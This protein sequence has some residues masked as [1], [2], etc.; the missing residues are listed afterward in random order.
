M[1][2]KKFIFQKKILAS[3]L[4]VVVLFSY[5]PLNVVYGC[6]EEV[7][8]ILSE[9]SEKSNEFIVEEVLASTEGF[10]QE[11]D[12]TNV[13]NTNEGNI[14]DL[15]EIKTEN[16]IINES[17][18]ITN[19][20]IDTNDENSKEENNVIDEISNIISNNVT[21]ST[22]DENVILG[23][24]IDNTITNNVVNNEVDNSNTI[25][26][27]INN[28]IIKEDV[29]DTE[30]V[31]NEKLEIIGKVIWEEIEVASRPENVNISIY[32]ENESNFIEEIII[33]ENENWEFKFS[34]LEKY[35]KNG[36]LINYII[37]QNTLENYETTISVD[38][39]GNYNILNK[40]IENSELTWKEILE[41]GP[42]I[43]LLVKYSEDVNEEISEQEMMI[44]EK[45]KEL[46]FVKG[47]NLA[48][49]AYIFGTDDFSEEE[50]AIYN[51]YQQVMLNGGELVSIDTLDI[52][53]GE[54]AGKQVL[55]VNRKDGQYL[56][57]F[58][59]KREGKN[60]LTMVNSIK[61]VTSDGAKPKEGDT[62]AYC[63][64]VYKPY[65]ED[66]DYN[67]DAWN[68]MMKKDEFKDYEP[69]FSKL[70]SELAYVVSIGCK[71][72]GSH[73]NSEYSTGA[74]SNWEEDYYVTQTVIY[75][76]LDDYINNFDD[77]AKKMNINIKDEDI[78]E[79][80]KTLLKD[81]YS[82]HAFDA[83]K[84]N[85]ED[86]SEGYGNDR[87]QV[88]Y[89]AV[90]KMYNA[91]LKQRNVIGNVDTEGYDATLTVTPET[92]K[93]KYENGNWI[94][95][96]SVNT[97]GTLKG[98]ISFSGP[99]GMET[100]FNTTTN[101]YTIK[102]PATSVKDLTKIKV[103]TIANFDANKF[104]TYM[105]NISDNQNVA[106]YQ[107]DSNYTISKEVEFTLEKTATVNIEGTKTWKDNGNEYNTRPDSITINLL[108]NGVKVDRK[109]VTAQDGWSW[110]FTGHARYD[111][112]NKEIKYTIT[113]EKV[114]GYETEIKNFNVINTLKDTT[115]IIGTKIWIDNNNEYNTRPDS[116]TINLLK[117]GKP[118]NSMV[119]KPD[120][121]GNW[122]YKFENLSKYDENGKL[123]VYTIEE[124][125]VEKY[126][127]VKENE[128]VIVNLLSDKFEISGI[129]I[130]KDNNN[131]YNTRPDSIIINLFKN[132]EFDQKI[133]VK[134]DLLGNWNFKFENLEMYDNNGVKYDY[135]ITE[136][137]VEKYETIIENDKE[138]EFK[139]NI[140][141]KLT[142]TTEV[143]GNKSWVDNNNA[144]GTRPKSI[145]LILFA[146]GQKIAEKEITENQKGNWD[147]A[148]TNLLKYD[149]N[150]VKIKY[151]IEEN[152]VLGYVTDIKNVDENKVELKNTL[153]GKTEI[154]GLKIWEDNNNAYAI[155]PDCITVNLLAN[156]NKVAETNVTEGEDGT[157]R[158]SFKD[159]DKYDE[160]GVK[161]EYAIAE[162]PVLGYSTII[163]G[164]QIINKVNER[165]EE[166]KS[167]MLDLTPTTGKKNWLKHFIVT[168][169]TSLFG[170]IFARKRKLLGEGK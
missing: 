83:L 101:T 125:K 7:N 151:T 79:Q 119:V 104:V 34:S 18:T 63:M 143:K 118:E 100:Q 51:A 48:Q 81:M 124:E 109:I 134:P 13:P 50:L 152:A 47:E 164:T 55:S 115:E 158:F 32:K 20:V 147:F 150:G 120:L 77:I 128:N 110:K 61:Y 46:I 27:V 17:N 105:C 41:Y 38:E 54:Y 106:F 166:Q 31:L 88:V 43:A 167:E 94:A 130:W 141:N 163:N 108:A 96:I 99:S 123:Y 10:V 73:N 135:T 14:I 126:I 16:V 74:N 168:A 149:E 58:V 45:Y 12:T 4:I 82:G 80:I 6:V 146:N 23:N 113:E 132:D 33:S 76:V 62:L 160:N 26:N 44:Y 138:F 161:I 29:E 111:S 64:N 21:N 1:E 78:K 3:L 159:L 60:D 140:T 92:Q 91:V 40:E 153:F 145:N 65:V 28:E 103:K 155:R 36:L 98:N 84:L 133:V 165:K 49:K 87:Q 69:F 154:S 107:N 169:I 102:I 85:S 89:N 5:M 53:E 157:W 42:Y 93:L 114:T 8:N 75:I 19:T 137:S 136:D 67:V 122:I 97:T 66:S 127:S 139:Y 22:T 71:T 72:Y 117:N 116:I 37:K 35:D 142:D 170:M 148:F 2:H 86:T 162:N 156:G 25:E 24:N 121:L 68:Q 15:N 56:Q 112:Q 95:N 59:I 9:D 129:K 39:N 131:A 144:Y 57:Y 30:N 90:E 52:E 11:E 70:Y